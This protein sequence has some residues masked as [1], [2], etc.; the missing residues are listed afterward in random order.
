MRTIY[1]KKWYKPSEI[2]KLGLILN[3]KG[4]GDYNFV[5][6]LIKSGR[7]R[8]KDYSNGKKVS[9]W[10]VPEDEIDRYHNTVTKI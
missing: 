8:A 6:N 3:S 9:Y 2:A 5:L 1:G 10:L 4:K 7:L